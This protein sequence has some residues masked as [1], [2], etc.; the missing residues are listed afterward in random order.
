VEGCPEGVGWFVGK[1]ETPAKKA[2][3]SAMKVLSGRITDDVWET[4]R[5]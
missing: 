1:Q 5:N 4:G 3:V 2:I